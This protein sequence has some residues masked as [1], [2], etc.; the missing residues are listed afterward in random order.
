MQAATHVNAVRS[1]RELQYLQWSVDRVHIE[2]L[3]L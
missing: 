3:F 2:L 1:V